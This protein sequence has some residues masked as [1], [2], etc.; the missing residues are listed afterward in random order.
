[1]MFWT[2]WAVVTSVAAAAIIC[3]SV[4]ILARG[5]VAWSNA[6]SAVHQARAH[7]IEADMQRDTI[8]QARAA[9]DRAYS[10]GR[11]PPT[12]DEIREAIFRQRAASN[13]EPDDYHEVTTSGDVSPDEL[14]TH[15]QGGEF[16]R[17]TMP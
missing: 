10:G 3:S 8:E 6:I 12:P 7:G 16:I 11:P 2:L 15:M 9:V 17:D 5:A 4:W 1:M 14:N 13:G